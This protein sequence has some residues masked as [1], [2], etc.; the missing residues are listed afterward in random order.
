MEKGNFNERKVLISIYTLFREHGRLTMGL[1][2]IQGAAVNASSTVYGKTT[3]TNPIE[4]ED[5]SILKNN[6]TN[7]ETTNDL[8][9]QKATAMKKLEELGL[10]NVANKNVVNVETFE[11][12]HYVRLRYDDGS[13][14]T[15]ERNNNAEDAK[16]SVDYGVT[17]ASYTIQGANA[18]FK[19]G[20]YVENVNISGRS[21][22]LTINTANGKS[23]NIHVGELARNIT[24]I[25]DGTMK[26]D[27]L[28][29]P[30]GMFQGNSGFLNTEKV[31]EISEKT[32]VNP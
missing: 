16:L 10:E 26:T 30:A 28:I 18:V 29:Q 19:A 4:D 27:K 5:I 21:A 6:H 17:G 2:S 3:T 23:T 11:N 13:V 1:N 8:S 32:V 25:P 31:T 20:K 22:S 12:G 9:S 7:E 24:I 15:M 14:F